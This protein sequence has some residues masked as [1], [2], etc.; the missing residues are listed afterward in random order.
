M[1]ITRQQNVGI[2]GSKHHGLQSSDLKFRE[3]KVGLEELKPALLQNGRDELV[4]ES[5]DKRLYVLDATKLSTS[6]NSAFRI[7]DPVQVGRYS[8]KI[9]HVD[10]DPPRGG[11]WASVATMAGS[12]LGGSLLAK[13]GVTIGMLSPGV[14]QVIAGTFIVGGFVGGQVIEHRNPNDDALNKLTNTLAHDKHGNF[15]MLEAQ[16]KETK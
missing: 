15:S 6:D 4:I 11:G 16:L 8:G 3:S 9:V 1:A 7:G 12:I 10:I 2:Q 5:A 14:G 13:L